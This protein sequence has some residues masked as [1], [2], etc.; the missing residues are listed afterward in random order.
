MQEKG[1]VQAGP[2]HAGEGQDVQAGPS[3]E[4]DT[5]LLPT[6]L[7]TYSRE[8]ATALVDESK[9]FQVKSHLQTVMTTVKE[10]ISNFK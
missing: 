5:D 2:S 3:P 4:A 9:Y 10:T 6:S 7:P 1:N 8:A